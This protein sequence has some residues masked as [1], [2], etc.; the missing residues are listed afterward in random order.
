MSR[1]TGE[2]EVWRTAAFVLDRPVCSDLPLSNLGEASATMDRDTLEASVLIM[3]GLTR[4]RN[5]F[6][7]LLCAVARQQQG[8]KV[9]APLMPA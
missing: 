9:G 5:T 1:R 2:G 4:L 8:G 3:D 6:L 7:S